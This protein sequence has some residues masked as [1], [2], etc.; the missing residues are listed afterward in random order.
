[1]N[2]LKTNIK[3]NKSPKKQLERHRKQKKYTEGPFGVAYRKSDT[4]S[5]LRKPAPSTWFWEVSGNQ[6][7][8]TES[9]DYEWQAPCLQF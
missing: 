5:L 2:P 1:M 4:P 3:K 6:V 9:S 8:S 7:L